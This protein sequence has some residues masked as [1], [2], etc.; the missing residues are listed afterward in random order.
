MKGRFHADVRPQEAS[1][2]RANPAPIPTSPAGSVYPD[3]GEPVP[4]ATFEDCF[5]AHR[6]RAKPTSRMI[7][8]ENSV[9]GR[10]A[11]IHHLLPTPTCTSSA[12]TSCRSAIQLMAKGGA[13]LANLK[14]V[15]SH[16]QALGQCRN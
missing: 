10:V 15:Q 16:V 9:A 4:C 5:A 14:S 7:P 13:T 3:Y 11:D 12:S 2:T 1:P 6:S 8:I